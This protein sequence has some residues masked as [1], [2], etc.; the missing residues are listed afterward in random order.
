MD[1]FIVEYDKIIQSQ[2]LQKSIRYDP[3]VDEWVSEFSLVI[4]K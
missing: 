3:N 2:T 1:K 4:G